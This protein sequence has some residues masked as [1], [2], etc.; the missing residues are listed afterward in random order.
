MMPLAV[1]GL[2]HMEALALIGLLAIASVAAWTSASLWQRQRTLERELSLLSE[3]VRLLYPSETASGTWDDTSPS[4]LSFVA[5]HAQPASPETVTAVAGEGENSV[6]ATVAS[7]VADQLLQAS[8]ESLRRLLRA[9]LDL[10]QP[11]ILSSTGEGSASVTPGKPR[12]VGSQE[13]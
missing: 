9:S 10:N 13:R 11:A 5:R 12:P 6:Q 8:P 4:S 3:Q 7:Y 1:I 2:P